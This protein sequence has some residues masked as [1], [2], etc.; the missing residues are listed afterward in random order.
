VDNIKARGETKQ[1]QVVE[2]KD[3]IRRVKVIF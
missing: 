3:D 2:D 1:Q